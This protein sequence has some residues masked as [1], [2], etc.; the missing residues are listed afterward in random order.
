MAEAPAPIEAPPALPTPEA[1][2]AGGVVSPETAAAGGMADKLQGV[3]QIAEAGGPIGGALE[4]AAAEPPPA[5]DTGETTPIIIGADGA[6]K[7]AKDEA[8]AKAGEAAPADAAAEDDEAK[9]KDEKKDEKIDTKKEAELK[10]DAARIAELNRQQITLLI[11]I[12]QIDAQM[13]AHITKQEQVPPELMDQLVDKKTQLANIDDEMKKL[14]E[15]SKKM[16]GKEKA[17][18]A[19]LVLAAI[20]TASATQGARG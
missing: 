19:A 18:M 7:A 17:I 4:A 13:T 9:D 20:M 12:R 3:L 15:K 6:V 1:P 8:A 16:T 5:V 10:G 11:E 14:D 2:A